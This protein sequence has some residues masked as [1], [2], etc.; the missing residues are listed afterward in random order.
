MFFSV[1]GFPQSDKALVLGECFEVFTFSF[2]DA[3]AE[4]VQTDAF[5]VAEVKLG[6]EEGAGG[7]KAFFGLGGLA[8]VEEEGNG[9]QV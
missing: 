9:I 8:E 7:L 1:E 2:I 3:G 6:F 5:W 4:E